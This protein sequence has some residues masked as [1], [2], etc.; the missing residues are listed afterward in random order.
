[1]NKNFLDNMRDCVKQAFK[2]GCGRGRELH[3]MRHAI[4][5]ELNRLGCT[6]SEIK[7]K[8]LEWNERCQK[9][10][11]ESEKRQQ[12]LG[13][14]DW[15]FK[16]NAKTGCKALEDYCIGKEKCKFYI[17]QHNRQAPV[18]SFKLDELEKFLQNRFKGIAYTLMLVVKALRRFQIEKAKKEILYV[19][20]RKISSIIRDSYGHTVTHTD[21]QRKMKILID[22]GIIQQVETGK[23]G[24]SS[25]QAN[26]Y[27]FLPW[28]CP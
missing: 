22:E 15:F 11:N 17:K 21:A 2:N 18:L 7:D 16:K 9:P 27:R 24:G 23:K 19:G 25:W 5:A 3:K 13:Y 14:V 20:F 8:L 1:M 26:G 6:P 12:L 28:R 10:F 4:I